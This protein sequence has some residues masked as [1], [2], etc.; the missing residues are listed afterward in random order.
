MRTEIESLFDNKPEAYSEDHFRIFQK[1]KEALNS[2]TVR[3]AEPDPSAPSGWRVNGWV[4]KGILL[5][6]RM[7]SVVDMSVDTVRQPF[8]DKATYPVRQFSAADGIRIVPG[9]SSIR[10][11]SYIGKGVICMPPMFR[12][13]PIWSTMKFLPGRSHCSRFQL[14]FPP[15]PFLQGKDF[16]GL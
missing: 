3:A 7:G 8:L 9:G 14:P 2:G 1:F 13:M 6:F 10:D 5:G 16:S 12:P 4:K 11:A 15:L